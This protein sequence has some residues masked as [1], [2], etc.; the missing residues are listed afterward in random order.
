M[1]CL[2]QNPCM[3]PRSLLIYHTIMVLI[4]YVYFITIYFILVHQV[5][6]LFMPNALK[7]CVWLG[8]VI[9]IV[10]LNPDLTAWFYLHHVVCYFNLVG[11]VCS[12]WI[13]PISIKSKC[14]QTQIICKVESCGRRN[15]CSTCFGHSVLDG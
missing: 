4:A 9:N 7:I 13:I 10:L 5:T 14:Q 12:L 8:L 2:D 3:L 1:S 11:S 6:G 15:C